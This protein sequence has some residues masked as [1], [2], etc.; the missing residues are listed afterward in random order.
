ME[1]K[2]EGRSE[3]VE[4]PVCSNDCLVSVESF[5]SEMSTWKAWGIWLSEDEMMLIIGIIIYYVFSL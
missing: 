2:K 4:S 3:K 5:C 1:V